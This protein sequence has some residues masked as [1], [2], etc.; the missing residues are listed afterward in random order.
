LP[1]F[2]W[3]SWHLYSLKTLVCNS[4]FWL[5]LLGFGMSVKLAL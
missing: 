2:C 4:L 5:S 1:V 3:E